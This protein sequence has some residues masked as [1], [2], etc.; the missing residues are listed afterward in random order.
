LALSKK[1][2]FP[3]QEARA[4]RIIGA[5]FHV[6]GDLPKA[7]SYYQKNL[8]LSKKIGHKKGIANALGNLAVTYDETG[9]VRKALDTY[10]E[11]LQIFENLGETFGVSLCYNNMSNTYENL[12]IFDS[13][14]YFSQKSII[15]STEIG[16]SI[17]IAYGHRDVGEIYEELGNDKKAIESFRRGL[18]IFRSIGHKKGVV[19]CLLSLGRQS[20]YANELEESELQLKEALQVAQIYSRRSMERDALVEIGNLELERKKYKSTLGYYEQSLAVGRQVESSHGISNSLNHIADVAMQIGD[21]EKAEKSLFEALEIAS[22]TED[23]QDISHTHLKYS[24][25]YELKKDFE[26]ALWHNKKHQSLN[27][28]IYN[29]GRDTIMAEMQERFG[30]ERKQ[31]E[32]DLLKA[33]AEK[34]TTQSKLTNLI[35]LGVATVRVFALSF[36]FFFY[37]ARNREKKQR[38]KLAEKNEQI[39]KYNFEIMSQREEITTQKDLLEERF[40]KVQKLSEEK[41][42]L[43]GVVAHDLKSPLNQIRGF[44]DILNFERDSFSKNAQ[45]MQDMIR[46]VAKNMSS[47]IVKILDAQQIESN[48]INIQLEKQDLVKLVQS[49]NNDF[50]ILAEKKSIQLICKTPKEQLMVNVDGKLTCQIFE[51]LLSNAI[52]FSEFDKQIEVLFEEDK[53]KI[54]VGVKDQGPRIRLE[55]QEKLFKKIQKLSSKPTAEESSTG[56]GLF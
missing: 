41:S 6:E 8:A 1:L 47:M 29:T 46:K 45:D 42:Y 2:D 55:E 5:T 3:E 22:Y 20:R 30:A 13:S 37:K 4:Y 49:V 56:L 24:K 17:G 34:T 50:E 7:I 54:R 32:L 25:L 31:N 53:E 15:L 18:A 14:I 9:E 52:K 39:R 10:N 11:A 43:I 33:E 23:K 16:D 51:N 48:S 35:L 12:S 26:K 27:D 28:S 21:L 36:A 19:L 40:S 38:I 44:L